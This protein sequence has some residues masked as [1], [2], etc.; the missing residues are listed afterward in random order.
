MGR[1]KRLSGG[2]GGSGLAIEYVRARRVVR[3]LGW[4]AGGPIT[5]VEFPVDQL[6]PRLGISPRDIGAPLLFLLFAGSYRRPEGGLRD[7]VATFDAE[8]PAW[9]AFLE[10]RQAHPA[11]QGW[12]ELAAIDAQGHVDQ[13]AWFG[14]R[15]APDLSGATQPAGASRPARR[16]PMRRLAATAAATAS[17]LKAVTPS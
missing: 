1:P 15:P 14:L 3:L 8:E 10:L 5:P 6:C 2:S 16:R 13:L 4:S 7:L 17:Y 11:A 9:A 12:A